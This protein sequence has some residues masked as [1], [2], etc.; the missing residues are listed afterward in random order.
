MLNEMEQQLLLGQESK[1]GDMEGK[2][3]R[4]RGGDHDLKHFLITLTS[5]GLT[6]SYT[7]DSSIDLTTSE[8]V[9]SQ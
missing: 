3:G 5:F 9:R 7:K 8:A 4:E 1:G 2:W 6:L